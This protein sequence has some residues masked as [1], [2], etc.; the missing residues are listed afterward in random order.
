[1]VP[2]K[3]KRATRPTAQQRMLFSSNEEPTSSL[4][5]LIPDCQVVAVGKRRDGG[6]RYWCLLH[7]ADA[8]AKYGK[9]A[10]SCRAAH[11]PPILPSDVLDLN[12]DKYKGGIA[13]WGAVP[14]VYDT[15]R[16]PMDRGIHVHARPTPTSRKEM[17]CTFR[18]V[19]ILGQN[20]AN[21]GILI[22]E[23]DA[24]YYMVSSIFG[25]EMKYVTCSYCGYPHL[26]RDW[27]SVHPHRRHLCAGCGKHFAD[28]SIA[29]GNPIVGVRTACGIK[30]HKSQ[31]SAKTLSIKQ[32]DYPG[33]IQIW[34]SNPAFLWTSDRPEEEGVHVHAFAKPG[35]QPTLDET[36][37]EVVI[38]GI[39][40]DPLMVRVLMAQSALPSLKGRVLPIMCPRCGTA[41]F[42]LG[43]SAFTPLASHTCHQC[44]RNFASS[45]RLRKTIGNPLPTILAQLAE[46][47]PRPPQHHELGLLPETL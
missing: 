30:T 15:T 14:A 26:D 11:I 8:T 25:Y 44:S 4:A 29:V 32:A 37:R 24:I 7:K 13:L 5:R 2:I 38:D 28:T 39:K 45:G 41:H 22:S 19:K 20:L 47:A 18:A 6:I 34:G 27:F 1:M 36:Y 33:G 12:I 46:N 21:D 31:P 3:K 9:P 23:L 40:L 10:K 42:S 35:D 16:L 43:E 17:D